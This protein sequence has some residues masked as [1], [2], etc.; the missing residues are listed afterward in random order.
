MVNV[1]PII[2]NYKEVTTLKDL[3]LET[4]IPY[5]TLGTYIGG[6]S[7]IPPYLERRIMSV[8]ERKK[9]TAFLKEQAISG[10]HNVV[11]RV[12]G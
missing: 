6:Y 4:E 2:K 10:V 5:S 12:I 7:P 9:R 3:S 1:N 8:L 11:P